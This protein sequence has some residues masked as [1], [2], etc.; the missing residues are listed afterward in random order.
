MK[1]SQSLWVEFDWCNSDVEEIE[2]RCAEETREESFSMG[3][4][5]AQFTRAMDL[6][7][8]VH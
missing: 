3:K 2:M 5:V 4:G 6:L 7:F 1:Y 8:I